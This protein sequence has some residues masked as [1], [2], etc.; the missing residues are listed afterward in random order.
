MIK[1]MI[2]AF[3]VQIIAVCVI[4]AVP[5]RQKTM[6]EKM[7]ETVELNATE[8]YAYGSVNDA[9]DTTGYVFEALV[10][11]DNPGN[12]KAYKD[13]DGDVSLY[14]NAN[15]GECTGWCHYRIK[16]IETGQYM[17]SFLTS[18]Y[19]GTNVQS[20]FL[21]EHTVTAKMKMFGN[22]II[23]EGIYID[24]IQLEEYFG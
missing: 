14:R 4:I 17:F 19:R 1:K 6:V 7:G 23:L 13:F 10:S 2:A 8:V 5:S 24:G 21:K 18:D 12:L 3:L 9:D 20:V 15:T 22:R 16:D 11:Y